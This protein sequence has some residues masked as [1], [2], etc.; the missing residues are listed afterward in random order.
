MELWIFICKSFG[1]FLSNRWRIMQLYR[2]YSNFPSDIVSTNPLYAESISIEQS[3]LGLLRVLNTPWGK[4]TNTCKERF[5][6]LLNQRQQSMLMRCHSIHAWVCQHNEY[7]LPHEGSRIT[8]WVSKWRPIRTCIVKGPRGIP[9][10]CEKEVWYY[11]TTLWRWRLS[12]QKFSAE[13]Q[14]VFKWVFSNSS[15]DCGGQTSETS[16]GINVGDVCR[17][18]F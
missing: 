11:L 15:I 5:Y 18:L 1:N 6:H 16:N 2:L 13:K 8:C 12:K 10:F 14:G 7:G 9:N 3:A 17:S 4:V